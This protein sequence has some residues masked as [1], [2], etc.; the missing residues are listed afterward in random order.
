MPCRI[1][2][3]WLQLNTPCSLPGLQQV[4]KQEK[5]KRTVIRGSLSLGNSPGQ[6]LFPPLLSIATHW[7]HQENAFAAQL[8]ED[9]VSLAK[10]VKVSLSIHQSNVWDSKYGVQCLSQRSIRRHSHHVAILGLGTLSSEKAAKSWKVKS[11]WLSPAEVLLGWQA[12]PLFAPSWPGVLRILIPSWCKMNNGELQQEESHEYSWACH[13]LAV[14]LVHWLYARRPR[15]ETQQL[16]EVFSLHITHEAS[17][18]TIPKTH[19]TPNM[20][21]SDDK[22][23]MHPSGYLSWPLDIQESESSVATMTLDP[24]KV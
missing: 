13:T 15:Q 10:S 2:T 22:N 3:D 9:F 6:C 24:A 1:V 20:V 17:V 8:L 11:K 4:L 18:S 14:I 5:L 7:T 23:D 12:P 16:A 19:Q 21:D